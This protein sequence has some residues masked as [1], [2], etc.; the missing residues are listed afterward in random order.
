MSSTQDVG[1][2]VYPLGRPVGRY[3]YQGLGYSTTQSTK[4]QSQS[5]GYKVVI[6]GAIRIFIDL[7]YKTT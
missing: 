5:C 4:E 3:F 6:E 2:Q 7:R 1:N